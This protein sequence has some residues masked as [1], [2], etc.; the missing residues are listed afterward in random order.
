M[1]RAA[2]QEREFVTCVQWTRSAGENTQVTQSKK[3]HAQEI[4]NGAHTV[5]VTAVHMDDIECNNE[6][7]YRSIFSP[8]YIHFETVYAS[9]TIH[10]GGFC[11]PMI[12]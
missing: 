5:L 8:V 3:M 11:R 12:P 4:T 1:D 7:I 6:C 2:T 10:S 9:T